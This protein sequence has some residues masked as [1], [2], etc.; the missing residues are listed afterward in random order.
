MGWKVRLGNSYPSADNAKPPRFFRC[1]LPRL[2]ATRCAAKARRMDL[3]TLLAACP[4]ADVLHSS[5][6]TLCHLALCS[7]ITACF[8]A[9]V[10]RAPLPMQF[11]ATPTV[12]TL[13]PG[14]GPQRGER[15]RQV[16]SCR[17]DQRVDWREE[18]TR[19]SKE[20]S[21]RAIK[22]RYPRRNMDLRLGCPVHHE[23]RDTGDQR[24]QRGVA[25]GWRRSTR[26]RLQ[27]LSAPESGSRQ[28]R[29][30]H[31]SNDPLLLDRFSGRRPK[32]G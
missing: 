31:D 12:A 7:E 15:E 27:Y 9:G 1:W 13:F 10:L 32:E 19:A 29:I 17:D 28:P 6:D 14:H 30:R 2:L 26:T 5:D 22:I 18:P 11:R 23:V 20:G 4:R 3:R 25:C 24:R 21:T 16:I 8:H